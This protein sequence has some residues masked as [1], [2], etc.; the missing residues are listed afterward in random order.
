M[1]PFLIV[2]VVI[3]TVLYAFAWHDQP[4][5]ND[6][7]TDEPSSKAQPGAN[8]APQLKTGL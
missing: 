4:A 5:R 2:A 8:V 1:H 7:R 6:R 3:L